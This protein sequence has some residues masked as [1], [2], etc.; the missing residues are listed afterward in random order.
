MDDICFKGLDFHFLEPQVS[1]DVKIKI[2]P[3]ITKVNKKGDGD[4][5]ALGY[6]KKAEKKSETS[7]KKSNAFA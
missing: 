5:E 7:E 4:A 2:K 6:M 1:F 3:A